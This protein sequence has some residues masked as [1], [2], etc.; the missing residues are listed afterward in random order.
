MILREAMEIMINEILSI[1]GDH[2]PSIYLYGSV[3]TGDF[4]LGWSDIDILVLTDREITEQQAEGLVHL[5]Q[6]LQERYPEN[7]Y[8]RLFE[9]GMLSLDAFL[10][11]KKERTVYWGTRGQRI[12]DSYIF[13]SL[14]TAD[15]LDY[16]VVLYGSDI[17]P[18]M[19][20]PSYEQMREDIRLHVQAARKY[21]EEVGWLLDIARGIYTLRTG[22][23]ISK[24][25]A[26]EWALEQSLCPDKDM[27]QKALQIRKK[28]FRYSKE[29]RSI[30][31]RV[32]QRF[33]DVLEGYF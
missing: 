30:D 21:G 3:A 16:G 33:A 32:I 20:Y 22:K 23:I 7:P 5:R 1:L 17:R 6:K 12:V 2:N 14:S 31:N 29:D 24:T 11:K 28:P 13:N 25:K 15:L 19:T 26:G 27:L 10:E 18:K 9:G 8:F 4:K